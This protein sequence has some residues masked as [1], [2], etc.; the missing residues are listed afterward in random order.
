[1]QNRYLEDKQPSV[2]H[3][4]KG[5]GKYI[6]FD[7]AKT[8]Y[9]SQKSLIIY[10]YGPLWFKNGRIKEYVKA[11]VKNIEAN[12]TSEACI[13]CLKWQT[14]AKCFYFWII[15][16]EHKEQLLNCISGISSGVWGEHF[17]VIKP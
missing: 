3:T 14:T 13:V 7:E 10:H 12:T 4:R 16:K 5:S 17:K 9:E 2:G 15:R 6:F 8:I 11:I 1:M